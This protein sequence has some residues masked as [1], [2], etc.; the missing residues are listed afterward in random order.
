M[1][2]S[3]VDLADATMADIAAE[4]NAQNAAAELAA[5]RDAERLGAFQRAAESEARAADMEMEISAMLSAPIGE[6]PPITTSIAA[7]ASLVHLPSNKWVYEVAPSL[8]KLEIGL[9]LLTP[10]GSHAAMTLRGHF[11]GREGEPLVED[12]VVQYTLPPLEGESEKTGRRRVDRHRKREEAA[13][14][15]LEDEALDPGAKK[16]R[17]EVVACKRFN[18]LWTELRV[19]RERARRVQEWRDGYREVPS[20]GDESEGD[21]RVAAAKIRRERRAAANRR[22]VQL[23]ARPM[24]TT[25]ATRVLPQTEETRAKA[26]AS[27]SA[28]FKK[29]TGLP[30]PAAVEWGLPGCKTAE[31]GFP[32]FGDTPRIIERRRRLQQLADR[33]RRMGWDGSRWTRDFP[34]FGVT[35][36]QWSGEQFEW[37]A[38]YEKAMGKRAQVSERRRAAHDAALDAAEAEADRR[39]EAS[40]AHH[41]STALRESAVAPIWEADMDDDERLAYEVELQHAKD[42][43]IAHE[44]ASEYGIL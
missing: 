40:S 43:R 21:D 30:P 29:I 6:S 8:D 18:Q 26:R 41:A 37:E 16:R 34:A 15:R 31:C 33:D 12:E 24:T 23:A 3:E 35:M 22:E 9:P 1:P 32:V 39:W 14:I 17:E 7:P 2:S 27:I 20:S 42:E 10:S 4:W 5:A 13:I 44:A 11:A 19:Q 36:A 25:T 38:A 28:A